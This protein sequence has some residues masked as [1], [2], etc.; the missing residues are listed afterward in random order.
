MQ[1]QSCPLIRFRITFPP[2]PL[3]FLSSFTNINK[4]AYIVFLAELLLAKTPNKKLRGS[5]N[6]FTGLTQA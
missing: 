1:M 5:Q 3:P 2:L 6:K 4:Q